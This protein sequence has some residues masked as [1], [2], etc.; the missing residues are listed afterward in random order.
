LEHK[1]RV[2]AGSL[3][4]ASGL[5]AAQQAT[6]EV[7]TTLAQAP[8]LRT[9]TASAAKVR[10]DQILHRLSRRFGVTEET[11]RARLAELRRVARPKATRKPEIKPAERL[12]P[13]ERTLLELLLLA[14]DEAAA[15]CQEIAD[16]QLQ[17]PRSQIIFS[18]CRQL[19][20]AGVRPTF[21]RLMLEFDDPQIKSLLV[22]LD[23]QGRTKQGIDPAAGLDSLRQTF[24]QQQSNSRLNVPA[25]QKLEFEQQVD[26]L[27][28]LIER[29][30]QVA[31]RGS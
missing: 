13:R 28:A 27:G 4:A 24:R 1:F 3:D 6:E 25:E 11:L 7:L 20:N 26:L 29:N 14:P 12:P 2:A 19:C 21:E 30:R 16:N 10:E 5:H 8:R 17:S 31:H 9:D 15:V 23:E 22:E 18:T